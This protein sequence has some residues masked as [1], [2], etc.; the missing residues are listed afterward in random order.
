[1]SAYFVEQPT[2]D[3]AV[4]AI[5]RAGV[6]M[7]LD[8][9][10][11]IGRALWTLNAEAVQARYG[12]RAEELVEGAQ[13]IAAYRWTNRN[14]PTPVLFKSLECLLYQCNEGNVPEAELYQKADAIRQ[15]LERAGA[16]TA[17]EYEA[18]PWGLCA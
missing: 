8:E 9:A 4:T 14:E 18:A 5:I 13:E 11:N 2:V 16:K 17:P 12:D 3:A 6:L 7:S 1:M 15:A 10:N